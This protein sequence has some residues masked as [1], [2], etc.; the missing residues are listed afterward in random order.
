MSENA[1]REIISDDFLVASAS[2]ARE[3]GKEGKEEEKKLN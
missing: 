1:F 3:N 2:D